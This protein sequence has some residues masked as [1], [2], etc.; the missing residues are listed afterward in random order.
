MAADLSE[1]QVLARALIQAAQSAADAV[2]Q[3][4][5]A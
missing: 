1:A 2:Q 4:H 3:L 5:A